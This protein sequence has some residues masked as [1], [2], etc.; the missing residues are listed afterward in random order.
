MFLHRDTLISDL[1]FICELPRNERELFYMFPS[2][3]Y[4]LKVE[5]MREILKRREAHTT[6]FY[7]DKIVG[8]A[9]IYGY[10]DEKIPYIGHVIL[11]SEYRGRGLGKK[12][13][14]VMI[15]KAENLYKNDKIRIAVINENTH[16]FLLYMKL[17]FSPFKVSLRFDKKGDPKVLVLMERNIRETKAKYGDDQLQGVR[18]SA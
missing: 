6:F 14:E 1:P 11:S 15:E 9:N 5:Q 10:E 17:G 18:L 16:A 4:P 7:D 8:Y 13:I 2:A 12:M 3:S